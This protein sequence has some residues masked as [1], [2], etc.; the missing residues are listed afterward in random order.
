[1][2]SI[3][4][5]TCVSLS[6]SVQILS[7]QSCHPRMS[8]AP[9]T[10]SSLSSDLLS[11]AAKPDTTAISVESFWRRIESLEGEEKRK[12]IQTRDVSGRDAVHHAC[13]RGNVPLTRLLLKD[14]LADI[15]AQDGQG[16]TALH[17]ALKT[18]GEDMEGGRA[19]AA[20]SSSSA[21]PASSSSSSADHIECANLILD[22]AERL[23]GSSDQQ[24]AKRTKL[25]EDSFAE[26]TA[27]ASSSSSS[28]LASLLSSRDAFGRLP[29]HWSLRFPTVLLRCLRPE[30]VGVA[31]Q[32]GDTAL[33]WASQDGDLDALEV[34]LS[35]GARIDAKNAR[36]ETVEEV[37]KS[38]AIRQVI[39]AWKTKQNEQDAV[40]TSANAVAD[41]EMVSA[42]SLSR[43]STAPRAT[44]SS[45]T[46]GPKKK[47]AIKMKK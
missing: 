7:S 14:D 20:S 27:S 22:A 28:P 2:D 3:G 37:A 32:S 8:S 12:V 21:K 41:S 17:L 11:L 45:T 46:S 30:L 44:T 29:L 47:V 31:T 4:S 26:S 10:L 18:A 24:A 36:G 39:Q 15:L 13:L 38:D 40:A 1:V 43:T 5:S 6:L 42:S 9:P 19:A 23:P 16:Q 33:H 35:A 34:L 25:S